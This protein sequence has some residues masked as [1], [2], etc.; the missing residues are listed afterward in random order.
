MTPFLWNSG[1][2]RNMRA[3]ID[4]SFPGEGEE[5]GCKGQKGICRVMELFRA[6]TGIV[7]L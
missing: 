3:K 2:S 1:K 7:I 4:Q 5:I 6:L